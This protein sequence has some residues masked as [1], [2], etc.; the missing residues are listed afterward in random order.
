MKAIAFE[1]CRGCPMGQDMNSC[2]FSLIGPKSGIIPYCYPGP[3][4]PL[5]DVPELPAETKDDFD[6]VAANYN[7]DHKCGLFARFL[8]KVGP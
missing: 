3:D 6:S 5:P 8:R 2:P 7:F 1:D 4:C